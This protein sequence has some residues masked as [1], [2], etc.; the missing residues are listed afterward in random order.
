[1]N[2]N[3]LKYKKYIFIAGG[4]LFLSCALFLT[5]FNIYRD[6]M[7]NKSAI[8]ALNYLLNQ[9]EIIKGNNFIKNQIMYSK[10][11]MPT[12]EFEG[13]RYIG[14]IEI[15]SIELVL[16]IMEELDDTKLKQTACR[17]KGSVYQ[18]NMIIAGHDYRSQFGK[19]KKIKVGDSVKF[20]DVKGNIF[21]YSVER[22]EK[23]IDTD[24]KKM[25][26]GDWDLTLFTCIYN[27]SNRYTIRCIRT[28]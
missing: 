25:V 16:P 14:I 11:N 10:R 26:T 24:I 20:I 6:R 15:P 18:D 4:I 19:L 22:I 27:G 21:L 2:K 28:N 13:N 7:A 23:L 5:S 1:M 3:R 9:K 12:I 8:N 17:Y